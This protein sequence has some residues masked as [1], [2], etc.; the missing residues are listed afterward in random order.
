MPRC[1]VNVPTFGESVDA[2]AQ[3]PEARAVVAMLVQRAT[4][5]PESAPPMPG[6]KVRII[7]SY[8]HPGYPALRLFYSLKGETVY[9]IEVLPWDEL[10]DDLESRKAGSA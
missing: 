1:V 9:L 2:Y 6:T 10:T 4:A 7:R 5:R 3:T 8:S